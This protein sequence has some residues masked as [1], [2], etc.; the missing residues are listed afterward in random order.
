V[1]PGSVNLKIV[2]DRLTI[3]S[4]CLAELQSLPTSN[5]EA[6][7]S[8]PRNPASAE[9][10]LRRAIQA[11]FDATRHILSMGFGLGP[12]E[13]KEV[14][15]I[16]GEKGLIADPRLADRFGK[17]AGYRNRLT[18]YYDLVTP[19]ELFEISR[20]RLGDVR[21]IAEALRTAATDLAKN[22]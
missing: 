15:R 21:A 1:T 4:Q 19:G 18:H 17:M 7:L 16:A 5:R 2:E 9:S 14:A 3:V 11:L 22:P 12:L 6:F 10:F 13:Y 8:D 20:D